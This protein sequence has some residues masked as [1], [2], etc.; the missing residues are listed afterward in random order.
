MKPIHILL[1]EDNEG[2]ILLTT[3]ALQERKIVNRI[4]VLKD[5]KQAIDFL[6]QQAETDG[7]ELP[8]LL[9]LDIN[10]PKRNG[11]EVLEF[12]KTNDKLKHLPV[13]ILT[14]SSSLIDINRSYKHYANCYIT[15]PVEMDEFM[16]AIYKIE[17]FWINLVKLPD[18]NH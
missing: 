4:S 2:D 6:Y 14:T 11:H 7:P 13:I 8:D 5:G 12:I 17:S 10:L 15:K 18:T 1:V 9:L 16:E 3:E